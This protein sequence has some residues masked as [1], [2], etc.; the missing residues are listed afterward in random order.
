MKVVFLDID[1]V[2]VSFASMHLPNEILPLSMQPVDAFD[3]KCVGRLKNILDKT[4]AKI[5]LTSS[6]RKLFDI[7]E[8]IE[9]F[10]NH[11]IVGII[12]CTASLNDHRGKEIQLWLDENKVDKFVILDDDDDMLHLSSDLVKTNWKL[13]L[14]DNDMEL[15]IEM[16]NG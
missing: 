6:W 1:G 5:V 8:M 12:D 11:G 10:K 16:L 3:E 9:H 4:G 15:A 7:A 13:G 2:L 14:E